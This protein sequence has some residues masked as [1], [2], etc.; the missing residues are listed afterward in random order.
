MPPFLFALELGTVAFY[1]FWCASLLLFGLAPSWIALIRHHPS[2]RAIIATNVLAGWTGVGW[3]V[4]LV[5]ACR[6]FER[7]SEE[8]DQD[9]G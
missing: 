5:W 7:A 8:R 2:T 1:G 3:V 4:A 6:R 9:A